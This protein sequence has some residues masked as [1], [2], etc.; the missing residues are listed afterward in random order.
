[1]TDLEKPNSNSDLCLSSPLK[2]SRLVPR[3]KVYLDDMA[4]TIGS[5]P[6][7]RLNH[8]RTGLRPRW[9]PDVITPISVMVLAEPSN[10]FF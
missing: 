6:L 10:K 2:P 5:Y 7:R 3:T 9:S 8:Q 4:L 1:M